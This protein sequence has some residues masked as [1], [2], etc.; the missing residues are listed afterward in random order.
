MIAAEELPIDDATAG[1]EGDEE[2]VSALA[3][4]DGARSLAGQLADPKRALYFQ[5]ANYRTAAI[6]QGAD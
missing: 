1:I 5:G 3:N 6:R 2:L 4:R